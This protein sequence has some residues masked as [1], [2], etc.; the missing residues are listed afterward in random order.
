MQKTEPALTGK[1][2]GEKLLASVRQMRSGQAA[3]KTHALQELEQERRAPSGAARTLL[4]V[5]AKHPQVLRELA[6]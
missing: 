6:P 2:L 3:R 5:A 4:C 1:Q